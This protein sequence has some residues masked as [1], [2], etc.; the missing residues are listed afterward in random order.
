MWQVYFIYS[1][2]YGI[3]YVGMSQDP[4]ERLIHHNKGGSSFTSGHIPWVL[5][6]T[7]FCK[8]SLDAGAKEKYYKSTGRPIVKQKL[9]VFLKSN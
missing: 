4:G 6:Y 3:T 9:A 7:E 8:D 2:K 5:F 1:L